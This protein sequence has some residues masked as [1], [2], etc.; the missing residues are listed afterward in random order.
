MLGAAGEVKLVDF[1]I[2]R[3]R[4][5]L[6]QSISGTLQG[7]FAYM[8]PEQAEGLHVDA[9]S[10]IFSTGLVLYEMLTGLRPLEGESETETLRRVR[11]ARIA[12]PSTLRP[13]IPPEVD[14]LVLKALAPSPEARHVTAA[15]MRREMAVV[16]TTLHSSADASMLH[17]FLADVF[18]E[19]VVPQVADA[20]PLSMDDALRLQLGALTPSVDSMGSTRTATGPSAAPRRPST[21]STGEPAPA[22]RSAPPGSVPVPPV[23]EPSSPPSVPPQPSVSGSQPAVPYPMPAPQPAPR[24]L[25]GRRVLVGMLALV[26]GVLGLMAYLDRPVPATL[27]VVTVPAAPEGLEI[28]V[29]GTPLTGPYAGNVGDQVEV[30]A[31]ARDFER[32]CRGP[33]SLKAASNVVTIE[34]QPR[35]V[36]FRFDAE[37]ANTTIVVEGVKE[38]FPQGTSQNVV[39]GEAVTVVW[40]APGHRALEQKYDLFRNPERRLRARLEPAPDAPGTPSSASAAEPPSAPPTGAPRG[41]EGPAVRMRP[42]LVQSVPAGAEVLLEGKVLGRTPLELPTPKAP[43]TLQLRAPGFAEGSVR[44]EPGAGNPPRLELVQQPPG[45]LSVRVEP[46]AGTLLLDGR[47]T[48]KNVLLSH[49]L[50]AGPHTLQARFLERYSPIRNIEIVAGKTLELPA[51]DLTRPEDRAADGVPEP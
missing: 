43:Q 24:P 48:G 22:P 51:V 5:S 36:L 35:M 14:A 12:P 44:I 39:L 9:R 4:G 50:P 37:P 45:Y 1:G 28:R 32:R 23:P 49:A 33:V 17:R 27:G 11:Q 10:D 40:Q 38:P 18:P 42:V 46:A 13:D 2:A 7:K 34:L 31:E 26:L 19:G 8:S 15:A 29:D 21:F 30:C 25:I 41:T 6:H 3:A 47:D 20:G 16:L